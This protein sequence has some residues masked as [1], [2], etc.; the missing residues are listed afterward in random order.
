MPRI[1]GCTQRSADGNSGVRL[2]LGIDA[3]GTFTDTAIYRFHDEAILATAKAP[4]TRWNYAEGILEALDRLP[5]AL[6]RQIGL[7]SVSTTLATNALVENRGQKVGLLLMPPYGKFKEDDLSHRPLAVVKGALEMTGD[8]I[9]PVEAAEVEAAAQKMV[10]AQGVSAFAVSGFGATINASHELEVME[11]VRRS[12]GLGVTCGHQVSAKLGLYE[13]AT[14][15][16]FNAQVVPYIEAFLEDLGEL[17]RQEGIHAPILVVKGDGTLM[18]LAMA[19]EFPVETVFSGPAASV[20]GAKKLTGLKDALVVDIGGTTTD[21]AAIRKGLV[22]TCERGSIIAGHR[23]HVQALNMRTKGLGGDSAIVLRHQ[24]AAIGPGRVTPMCY[25]ATKQPGLSEALDFLESD[26]RPFQMDT[27]PMRL[28]ALNGHLDASALE[29]VEK[30]AVDILRERPYAL[31]EL[32]QRLDLPYQ[33]FGGYS[34]LLRNHAVTVSALTP[35]D[36]LHAAG[37]VALWDAAA[38]RRICALHAELLGVTAGAFIQQLLQTFTH[39]LATELFEKLMEHD[40]DE[41]ISAGSP[42]GRAILA[43][44]L[45]QI[46]GGLSIRMQLPYPIIGVGAPAPKLLPE[47]VALFNTEMLTPGN[48]DVAN[49]IGAITSNLVIEKTVRI[50]P[51]NE[52]GYAIEGLAENRSF[53]ELEAAAECALAQLTED[54]RALAGKSGIADARIASSSYDDTTRDGFGV[55][56]FLGR[57]ISARVALEGREAVCT[58]E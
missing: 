40:V 23:T 16:I 14:T 55:E 24:Q 33:S 8:V 7:V 34:R 18:S 19:K 51:R 21:I 15:A 5:V 10:R 54:V 17:L 47:A 6:L 3:G 57:T 30:R 49:A 20:A 9:A 29:P 4:T 36:V 11:A 31:E 56:F 48:Y 39:E 52:G 45:G 37:R 25:L 38:A 13:R 32:T 46:G 26:L 28:V 41:D 22:E 53:D 50:V 42:V 2:G 27:L 58:Q 35:T 1:H 43:K 12:T 44:W